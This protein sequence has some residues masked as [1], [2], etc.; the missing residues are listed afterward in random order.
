M[1]VLVT[2]VDGGAPRPAGP[3]VHT[4]MSG[5]FWST[6]CAGGRTVSYTLWITRDSA[7]DLIGIGELFGVYPGIGIGG[8]LVEFPRTSVR[9]FFSDDDDAMAIY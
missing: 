2:R 6:E 9:L 4:M 3:A 8:G 7:L 5:L 1:D